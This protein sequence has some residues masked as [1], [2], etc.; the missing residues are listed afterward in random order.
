MLLDAGEKRFLARFLA[1]FFG[2]FAVLLLADLRALNEAIAS[3]QAGLLALSGL[4]VVQHGILLSSGNSAATIVN[5]CSGL[6]MVILLA[7]LLYASQ[8][9]ESRRRRTLLIFTPFLLAF[10]IARLFLT[11]RAF[12]TAGALFDYVHVLLWFVDS[13]VVLSIW[14]MAFSSPHAPAPA[15]NLKQYKRRAR[16]PPS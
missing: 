3:V 7:A 11:L 12:F 15:G 10:N 4:P 6:V 9:P 16:K 14:Y 2:L 13:A 1:I 5:E 8:M